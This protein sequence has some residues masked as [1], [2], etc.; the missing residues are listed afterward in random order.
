VE[1]DDKKYIDGACALTDKKGDVIFSTFDTRDLD[2][3]QPD[4]KCGTRIITG[5]QRQICR[6]H[7]TRALCLQ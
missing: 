7:R 5:R 4:M 6:D 2:A 3:S 1:S